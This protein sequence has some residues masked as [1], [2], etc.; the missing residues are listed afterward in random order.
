MGTGD[1]SGGGGGTL[2]WTSIP[3]RGSRNTPSRLH[4]NGN[5]D[6]FRQC[7]SV[8]LYLS[9]LVTYQQRVSVL[10]GAMLISSSLLWCACVVFLSIVPVGCVCAA[11][12]FL[13]RVFQ[14]AF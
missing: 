12:G 10:L 7:E 2:C 3:P 14:S 4:A 5:Q 11:W 8:W 9:L 1:K 6:K 13:A